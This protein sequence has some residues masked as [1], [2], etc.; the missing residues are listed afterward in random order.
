MMRE[1]SRREWIAAVIE[2]SCVE[3]FCRM[4]APGSRRNNRGVTRVAVCGGGGKPPLVG[5]GMWGI[6]RESGSKLPHS[7]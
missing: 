6:G 1:K 2:R 4:I 3:K 7:I 5:T